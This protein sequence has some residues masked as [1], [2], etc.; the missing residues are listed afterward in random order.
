[1]ARPAFGL[2]LVGWLCAA[3]AAFA[4]LFDIDS[5]DDYAGWVFAVVA[6]QLPAI[7]ALWPV[8]R[9]ALPRALRLALALSAALVTGVAVFWMTVPIGTLIWKPA[10]LEFR[11]ALL[12]LSVGLVAVIV[13]GVKFVRFLGRTPHP[14]GARRVL[15]VVGALGAAGAGALA[16][17]FGVAAR[18]EWLVVAVPVA[19]ALPLYLLAVL[20]PPPEPR[21]PR[22]AVARVERPG[23]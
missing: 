17:R 11:P 14:L 3:G 16:L 4:A 8:R 20:Q 7:V 1:M 10:W 12:G 22:A 23:D 19:W 18:P 2:V 5:T 6:V 21:I 15:L 13:A 9:E